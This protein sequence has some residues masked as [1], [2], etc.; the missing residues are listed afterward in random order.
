MNK[1]EDGDL[2]LVL[3]I[4]SLLEEVVCSELFGDL[5]A[6]QTDR[7][8]R[9]SWDPGE[10]LSEH[11]PAVADLLDYLHRHAARLN[12]LQLAAL[13][14][15]KWWIRYGRG[16]MK[17]E[18]GP[19]ELAVR[20]RSLF[21]HAG[22]PLMRSVLQMLGKGAQPRR[23]SACLTDAGAILA[24]LRAWIISFHS[25]SDDEQQP[26]DSSGASWQT[27]SKEEL[28]LD[29]QCKLLRVLRAYE[30]G[31]ALYEKLVHRKCGLSRGAH[32]RNEI[33]ELL[34]RRWIEDARKDGGT[35]LRHITAKGRE[36]LAAYATTT[37]DNVTTTP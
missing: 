32:A 6:G 11:A 4:E 13:N 29:P 7:P 37:D 31:E 14:H 36:V 16:R 20:G 21:Q 28:D 2:R 19:G 15:S 23:P 12:D 34:K 5:D 3:D 25:C 26:P 33:A 8:R 22:Q 9:S 18:D 35:L 24:E 10:P 1:P 17:S 27:V 30:P